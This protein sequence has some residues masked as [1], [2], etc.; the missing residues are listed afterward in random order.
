[1]FSQD[2]RYY[3][4]HGLYDFPRRSVKTRLTEAF[5]GLLLK[6]PAFRRQFQAKMKEEMIQPLVDVVERP[7]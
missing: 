5:L 3:K 2:H 6:A 1:V 4:R 7:S